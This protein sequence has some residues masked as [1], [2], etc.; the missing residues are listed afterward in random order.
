MMYAVNMSKLS[1]TVIIQARNS[2]CYF[3]TATFYA[4]AND[5][6][7]CGWIHAAKTTKKRFFHYSLLQ[8]LYFSSSNITFFFLHWH[9]LQIWLTFSFFI[10]SELCLY[11]CMHVCMYVYTYTYM[12]TYHA[13][14]F[15]S[16][17]VMFLIIFWRRSKMLIAFNGSKAYIF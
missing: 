13:P 3:H 16:L 14:L 15:N 7:F 8:Q 10:Y 2:G 6:L 9:P 12:H 1:P 11:V 4:N 5:A 17:I